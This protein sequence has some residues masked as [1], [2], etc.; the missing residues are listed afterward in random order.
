MR[1]TIVEAYPLGADQQP[2]YDERSIALAQ[3]S[4]RVFSGLGL[5]SEL[6][7]D[8]CPIH[9]IHVSDRGHFGFTRLRREQEGLPVV[10]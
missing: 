8:V 9:T 10:D 3:G 4:Q 5:W 7:A 6:E 1:T 2:G